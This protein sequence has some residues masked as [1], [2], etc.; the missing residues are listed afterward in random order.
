[1]AEVVLQL[2]DGRV[3][4]VYGRGERRDKKKRHTSRSLKFLRSTGWKKYM[5]SFTEDA[6]QPFGAP[7]ATANSFVT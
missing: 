2:V 1:M 4:S 7:A 5:G 3:M 6:T